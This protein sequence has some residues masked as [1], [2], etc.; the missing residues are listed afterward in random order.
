[1]SE[2]E[3]AAKSLRSSYIARHGQATEKERGRDSDSE[4]EGDLVSSRGT[5]RSQATRRGLCLMSRKTDYVRQAP[6]LLPRARASA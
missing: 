6:F 4:E 3:N 5:D 1:M 2:G